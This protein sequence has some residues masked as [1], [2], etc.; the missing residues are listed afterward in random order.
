MSGNLSP[1]PQHLPGA[2]RP[3]ISPSHALPTLRKV[4]NGAVIRCD[5]L[6]DLRPWIP[7]MEGHCRDLWQR[8]YSHLASKEDDTKPKDAFEVWRSRIHTLDQPDDEFGL[9]CPCGAGR[10]ILGQ[11][12]RS[13]RQWAIDTPAC[14][15]TSYEC[16]QVFSSAKRLLS[17]DRNA[18]GRY[19]RGLRV[20]KGVVG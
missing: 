8:E 4:R 11:Q 13:I 20:P 9:Y 14:P 5:R 7:M 10:D 3:D 12:F 17:P 1:K 15:A 6:A 18:L 19:H 2:R 16:E